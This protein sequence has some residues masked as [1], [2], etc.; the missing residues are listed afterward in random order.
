MCKELMLIVEVDGITLDAEEQWKKDKAR[1]KEL[2]DF[3]FTVL[4]FTDE[5]VMNDIENVERVLLWWIE[6]HPPAHSVRRPPLK[7]DSSEG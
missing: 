5:E 7:G 1:Q 4:R 2:E 6:N 3:G